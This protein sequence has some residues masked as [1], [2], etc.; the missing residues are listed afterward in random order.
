M[1][2]EFREKEKYLERDEEEVPFHVIVT[3]V[4]QDEGLNHLCN[5][6]C[7]KPEIATPSQK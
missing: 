5:K 1:N 4:S 3:K 2:W 7:Q 6:S